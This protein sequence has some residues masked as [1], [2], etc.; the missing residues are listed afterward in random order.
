MTAV[1]VMNREEYAGS[2]GIHDE[3]SPESGQEFSKG[4]IDVFSFAKP[5]VCALPKRIV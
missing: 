5:M 3:K 4:T 1:P 2:P